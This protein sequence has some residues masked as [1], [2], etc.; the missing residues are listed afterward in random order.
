MLFLFLFSSIILRN[1]SS[2]HRVF[3]SPS[4]AASVG[5]RGSYIQVKIDLRKML[6]EALKMLLPNP[7]DA[8][9]ILFISKW[10]NTMNTTSI[11]SFKK[12]N[13]EK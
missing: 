3:L 8:P 7:S 5:A 11:M 10:R 1:S 13:T 9:V 12:K 4:T 2:L 6:Y